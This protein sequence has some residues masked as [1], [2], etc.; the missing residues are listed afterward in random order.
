MDL[1]IICL[2]TGYKNYNQA[3]IRIYDN[4]DI[5]ICN[6]KTYNGKT[7]ILLNKNKYYK[8]YAKLNNNKIF[9]YYKIVNNKL[10][11]P[12]CNNKIKQNN[13]ITL[14]LTDYYY[15]MPIEKGLITLWQ[16]Q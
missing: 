6:K 12:F 7:N 11:I 5:L 10:I 2:E 4:N 3:D 8:I 14:Q 1:E 13:V 15:N 16:K 9:L